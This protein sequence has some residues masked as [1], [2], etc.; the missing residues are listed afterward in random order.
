MERINSKRYNTREIPYS[1]LRNSFITSSIL[2]LTLLFFSIDSAAQIKLAW[3]PST[4]PN[5][6]GYRVYYGTASRTYGTPINVGNVTTYTLNGLS[7]AVVYYIAVTACDRAN[8]ESDYSNE[9]SGQIS[10]TV[11][12]PTVLTGPTG[13]TTGHP[14]TYTTGGSSST[15]GHAVQYQFDWKGDGSDLSPW[16]SA[17]QSKTWTLAGTYN[18]RVRARCLT[19]TSVV[20]PWSGVLAVDV[21]PLPSEEVILDN[22]AAGVSNGGCSFTGDWCT[23]VSAGYYGVDSLYSCGSGTDAYRWTPT[24]PA[25]GSYEVYVRWTTHDNRSTTVPISVTHA[26]GTTTKTYNQQTG[27]QTWVLHGTY[28]FN[29]GTGGYVQLSGIYGQACADAVRFVP[30]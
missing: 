29:S 1:L 8:Y 11:S 15:L 22:A 10:E 30:P 13:G 21:I 6:A 5:V 27:G 20:S 3:D 7:P 12:R 16:G 17:T 14:C 26:G 28:N 25:A 18:V 19:H 9:V 24:I 23:S 4:G 2:L